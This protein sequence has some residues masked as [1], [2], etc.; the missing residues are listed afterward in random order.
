MKQQSDRR[1]EIASWLA[2]REREGLSFR[3]LSKISG[4]PLGTISGWSRKLCKEGGG[5]ADFQEVRVVDGPGDRAT[6]GRESVVRVIRPDG[7]VVEVE[8]PPADEI[9][10]RLAEVV[11]R[12]S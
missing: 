2:R 8:G 4:I 10:V 11:G 3:Q 7:C 9:G 1:G 5:G 12:W 6:R